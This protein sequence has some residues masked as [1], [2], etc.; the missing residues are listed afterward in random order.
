[1]P[2]T[3]A[4]QRIVSWRIQKQHRYCYESEEKGVNGAYPSR[5][6]APIRI[7]PIRFTDIVLRVKHPNTSRFNAEN[8][9]PPSRDQPAA[10]H[11]ELCG[12]LGDEVDQA[13][14]LDAVFG[15]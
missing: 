4:S 10:A 2:G 13:Y 15:I 11:I 9:P 8:G 5:F 12:K 6:M 3:C 7:G 14:D 1:M